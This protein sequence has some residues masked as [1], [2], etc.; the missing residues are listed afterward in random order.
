LPPD[1][2]SLINA[3]LPSIKEDMN[4]GLEH[5]VKEVKALT[6]EMNMQTS[7]YIIEGKIGVM[8]ERQA[9]VIKDIGNNFKQHDE[10]YKK[11]NSLEKRP[12]TSKKTEDNENE[13]I[14]LKTQNKTAYTIFGA[15]IVLLGLLSK[16]NVI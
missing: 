1:D 15:I 12:D 14:K 6:K 8:N 2:L 3:I 9:N 13:I 11:L 16:L 5:L 10:F 4:R 7:V